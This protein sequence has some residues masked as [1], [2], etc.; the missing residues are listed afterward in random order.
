MK[1]TQPT[2]CYFLATVLVTFELKGELVQQHKNFVFETR[3]M[4]VT[5]HH[6]SKTNAAVAQQ[7]FQEHGITHE[8]INDMVIL[9][10]SALGR[11]TEQEFRPDTKAKNKTT[12]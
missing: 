3:N 6:L 7:L 12:H 1:S 11:M 2:T 9:N 10:I 8:Q 5:A 4:K